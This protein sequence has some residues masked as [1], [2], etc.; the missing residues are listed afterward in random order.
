MTIFHCLFWIKDNNISALLYD[1]G[2]LE[3][4]K[5]GGERAVP[6]TD[7]YWK[8]WKEY[9]GMCRDDRTDFCLIYDKKTQPAEEFLSSQCDSQDCI[10]CRRR[11]KEA[12]ELLE[13]QEPT[14]IRSESGVV[15]AKAGRFMN[16]A[17]NDIATMTA[18]YAQAERDAEAL[19]ITPKSTTPLI[20]YFTDKLK[21]CKKGYER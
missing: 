10:W 7:S 15:L 13:I 20:E 6:L 17:K 3:Q 16:A 4:L 21:A 14:E 8:E 11:I 19:T 1:S 9:S 5:I 12:V 18:W 2:R